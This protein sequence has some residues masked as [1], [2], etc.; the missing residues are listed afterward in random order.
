MSAASVCRPN[1][2]ISITIVG[3]ITLR[4]TLNGITNRSDGLLRFTFNPSY[5]GPIHVA[6][7]F[8][9][10]LKFEVNKRYINRAY[11]ERSAQNVYGIN[12][13]NVTEKDRGIYSCRYLS[14]YVTLKGMKNIKENLLLH[15]FFPL[16]N[17]K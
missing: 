2:T 8:L 9:K 12:L 7:I 3:D 6:D 13:K 4:W 5:T 10:S 16:N 15:T 14:K 17:F 1:E 11:L